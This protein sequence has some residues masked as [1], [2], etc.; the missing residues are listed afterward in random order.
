V[1]HLFMTAHYITAH[2]IE[3]TVTGQSAV[4]LKRRTLNDAIRHKAAVAAGSTNDEAWAGAL[5]TLDGHQQLIDFIERTAVP[6]RAGFQRVP[7]SV[8]TAIQVARA[9]GYVV[10]PGAPK[11]ITTVPSVTVTLEPQIVGTIAVQTDE[12]L[13]TM[14]PGSYS[15]INRQLRSAIVSAANGAFLEVLI[16]GITALLSSGVG[17][18]AI[19]TDAIELLGVGDEVV[20]IASLPW[21]VRLYAALGSAASLVTV[22]IAPEAADRVIAVDP[23]AVAIAWEDSIHIDVSK[24]AA[25]QMLDD[26]TTGATSLVSMFQ[27]DSSALRV[28][29]V[30][31]WLRVRTDGVRWL[32]MASAS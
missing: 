25:L 10:E 9:T 6:F 28:H 4:S 15:A 8:P 12:S 24:S 3:G 30:A 23:R 22:V 27:T 13:G 26:P 2:S 11:P 17:D 5:A 20:L 14:A 1:G 21:A 18:E 19:F 29:M 31:N 7:F 32:D 16:A